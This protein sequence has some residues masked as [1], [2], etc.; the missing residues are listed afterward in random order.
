[1]QRKDYFR[2]AG[3]RQHAANMGIYMDHARDFSQEECIRLAAGTAVFTQATQQAKDAHRNA[4]QAKR[5]RNLSLLPKEDVTAADAVWTEVLPLKAT[6][7]QVDTEQLLVG[8]GKL[9]RIEM[10][11]EESSV[12]ME[13]ACAHRGAVVENKE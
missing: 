8:I 13:Q 9:N 7:N 11:A 4:K 2:E 3:Q 6:R 1:D 12:D 5:R 10:A